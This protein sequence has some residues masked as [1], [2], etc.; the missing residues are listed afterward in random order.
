MHLTQ[1]DHNVDH[2]ICAQTWHSVLGLEQQHGLELSI[3]I[4][5]NFIMW[6]KSYLYALKITNEGIFDKNSSVLLNLK[7]NEFCV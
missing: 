7:K 2:N 3:F 4:V 6:F 5:W 1:E